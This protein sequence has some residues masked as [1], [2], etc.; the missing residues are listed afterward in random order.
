MRGTRITVDDHGATV[1]VVEGAVEV[2]TSDGGARSLVRPGE[3][4]AVA[5]AEL[6]RLTVKGETVRTLVSPATPLPAPT[7]ATVDTAA[8]GPAPAAAEPVIDVVA[9]PPARPRR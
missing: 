9:P 1:Q 8:V 4:A 5:A 7:P 3:V 2:A 6:G